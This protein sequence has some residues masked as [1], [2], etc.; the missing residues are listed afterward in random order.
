[1]KSSLLLDHA[2]AAQREL[3]AVAGDGAGPKVSPWE[4]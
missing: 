4:D 1:M 2:G 3:R